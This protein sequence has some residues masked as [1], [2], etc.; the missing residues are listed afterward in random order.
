MQIIPSR[1]LC[2]DEASYDAD[3]KQN[4]GC[5]VCT[6]EHLLHNVFFPLLLSSFSFQIHFFMQNSSY[7]NFF[8]SYFVVENDMFIDLKPE[9]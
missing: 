4:L 8:R 9:K 2:S 7:F 3:S 5:A 1:F 6:D